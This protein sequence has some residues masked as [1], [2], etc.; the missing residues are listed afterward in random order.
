M[1]RKYSEVVNYV[2]NFNGQPNGGQKLGQAEKNRS[3][4]CTSVENKNLQTNSN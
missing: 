1:Q 2:P 4:N 3:Y